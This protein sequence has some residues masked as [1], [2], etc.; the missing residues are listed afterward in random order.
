MAN[1]SKVASFDG[2]EKLECDPDFLNCRQEGSS[3]E[4]IIQ[5]VLEELTKHITGL[6][7][8]NE[9]AEG[10]RVRI[11]HESRQGVTYF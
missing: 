3:A 11:F 2:L 4:P 8:L 9:G 5:V 1:S 6:V 7:G 10:Q